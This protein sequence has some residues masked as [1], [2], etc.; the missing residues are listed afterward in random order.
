MASLSYPRRQPSKRLT[1]AVLIVG[2]YGIP[3]VA[4]A[5]WHTVHHDS[6]LCLRKTSPT[7]CTELTERQ[8]AETVAAVSLPTQQA[9]T[10]PTERA[11]LTERHGAELLTKPTLAAAE[12]GDLRY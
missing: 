5:T 1:R 6:L 8:G 10:S 2:G 3:A 4:I 7:D 9:K 12:A 11:E